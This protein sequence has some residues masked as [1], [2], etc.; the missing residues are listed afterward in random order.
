MI[1]V[2]CRACWVELK[3]SIPV[4]SKSVLKEM[5]LC[6]IAKFR[7]ALIF[8]EDAEVVPWDVNNWYRLAKPRDATA[9]RPKVYEAVELK[10]LAGPP[11]DLPAHARV[12]DLWHITSGWSLASAA[13][14]TPPNAKPSFKVVLS[15]DFAELDEFK[16]WYVP[17][18]A[19]FVVPAIAAGGP[20]AAL[21]SS[22]ASSSSSGAPSGQ[23]ITRCRLPS[24][25]RSRR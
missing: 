13:L 21:A 25:P 22:G 9:D 8:P 6:R 15:K 1:K 2:L 7:F 16:R 10:G 5:L 3:D 17:L 11:V 4:R 12:T 23:R 18:S 14:Q 24:R 20:S 19:D